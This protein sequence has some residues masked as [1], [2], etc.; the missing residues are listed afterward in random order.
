MADT[1]TQLVNSRVG[2]QLASR[3]GLP[4]P[5]TLRRYAPGDPLVE[6][7]VLVA[8]PSGKHGRAPLAAHVRE[9]LSAER[10]DVLADADGPQRLAAVVAD[11]SAV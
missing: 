10:I 7:P 9:L 2:R 11:L 3:L 8:G 5:T 1:Y 4:R 6:G